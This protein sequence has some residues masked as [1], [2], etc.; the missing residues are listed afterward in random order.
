MGV[1]PKVQRK[2]INNL[3]APCLL[4]K[5]FFGWAAQGGGMFQV[6]QVSAGWNG[7]QMGMNSAGKIKER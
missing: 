6:E 2:Q 4:G 5:N 1:K 3:S 7:D